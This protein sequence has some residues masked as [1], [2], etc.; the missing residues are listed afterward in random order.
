MSEYTWVKCSK[1]KYGGNGDGK[2]KYGGAIKRCADDIGCVSTGELLNK[3][4]VSY[5]N[6]NIAEEGKLL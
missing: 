5:A 6:K 1:C 4:K 2:C 3:Y